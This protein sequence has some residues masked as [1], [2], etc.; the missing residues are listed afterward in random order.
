MNIYWRRQDH[1]VSGIILEATTR[2]HDYSNPGTSG[3]REE[4]MD[5][6]QQW[7]TEHKCGVRTS[8]DMFKFK[9]E[10]EVVAFLLKWN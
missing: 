8:F 3:L 5:P 2:T 10:A 9:N 7:C 6:I 1:G 4:D